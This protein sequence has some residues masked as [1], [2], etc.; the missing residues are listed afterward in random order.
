MNV[1][2]VGMSLSDWELCARL[3]LPGVEWYVVHRLAVPKRK[4]IY[5]IPVPGQLPVF[6]SGAL[7]TPADGSFPWGMAV[8]PD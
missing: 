4:W 7:W 6:T 8:V 2:R 5:R 1:W 3:L